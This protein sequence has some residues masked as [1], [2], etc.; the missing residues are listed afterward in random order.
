[1]RWPALRDVT[2]D[3]SGPQPPRLY[4]LQKRLS[5]SD[6]TCQLSMATSSLCQS[7]LTRTCTLG[8]NTDKRSFKSA[9]D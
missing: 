6:P 8:S 9:V 1:M 4:R 2:A 7:D 5:N 3:G